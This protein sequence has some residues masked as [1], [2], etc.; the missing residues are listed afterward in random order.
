MPLVTPVSP[1]RLR[2]SLFVSVVGVALTLICMSAPARDEGI[3][4]KGPLE[5]GGLLEGRVE[6]G[7]RVS[8][9][10]HSIRVS[11]QG[12]FVLGFDRDAPPEADVVADFPDGT[13]E[14]RVLEIEKR[15]Y[16][17]QR[18]NGL[19]PREVTPSKKD[20]VR[21][22]AEA[23]AVHETRE[24]DDPRTDFLTGFQWPVI[25]RISGVYGSQRILNG[26]PRSPHNGVDIAAPAGTPVR[27]PAD[28]VVT[29]VY[30]DMYFSGNTLIVDHG[31]G[32]S[33]VFLHLQKIL[34]KKGERV[35]RGQVIGRVGAT[36]RATGPHLHWGVNL[37]E[38]RLDP[39]LLTG[40]MPRPDRQRST[41]QGGDAP[42]AGG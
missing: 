41:A 9:D 18:I 33:S 19:P 34:V 17:I 4:L 10:G 31:H 36:G 25:G 15:H 5:Q 7:T 8:V 1:P 6:P 3:T 32:L 37:F 40:S 16:R 22:R 42:G 29:L 26:H 12:V 24:R 30:P 38:N 27:A 11:P 35:H 2:G 20:L 14:R 23:A 28:G 13:R 21:I 39:A